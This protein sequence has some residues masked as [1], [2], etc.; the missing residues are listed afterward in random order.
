MANSRSNTGL[1]SA[2]KRPRLNVNTQLEW[3]LFGTLEQKL[4]FIER[5]ALQVF[6]MFRFSGKITRNQLDL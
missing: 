1:V 5:E 4:F 2:M 6:D 3:L